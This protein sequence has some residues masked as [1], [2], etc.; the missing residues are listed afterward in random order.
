MIKSLVPNNL[1]HNK[2][3]E[4]NKETIK[5]SNRFEL[6]LENR[7][8]M[9]NKDLSY[10]VTRILKGEDK[11]KEEKA[12]NIMKWKVEFKA[13]KASKCKDLK[14]DQKKCKKKKKKE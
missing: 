3:Y 12:K 4:S 14:Y 9:S 6:L 2:K 5:I 11:E 13:T 7:S 1:K 10:E 8:E